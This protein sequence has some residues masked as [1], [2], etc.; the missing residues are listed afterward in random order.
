MKNTSYNKSTSQIALE[1][2]LHFVNHCGL[3]ISQLKSNTKY[4]ALCHDLYVAITGVIDV[5]VHEDSIQFNC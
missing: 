2:I 5:L 4:T 1:N 3:N